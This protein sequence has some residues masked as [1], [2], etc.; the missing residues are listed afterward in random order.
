MN[1]L[2]AMTVGAILLVLLLLFSS[3]YTVSFHE[4]AIKSTFGEANEEDVITEPGLQFKLPFF[5]DNVDKFDTRLNYLQLADEEFGTSDQQTVV[6]R[7]F[8][9][10][11]VDP[12]NA[13]AFQRNYASIEEARSLLYDGFRDAM[14]EIGKFRFDDLLGVDSRIGEAEAA[15]MAKLG[16]LQ[17]RGIKVETVGISHLKLPPKATQAVLNRMKA[18]RTKLAEA[19][20]SRGKSEAERI[21]SNAR[22]MSSAIQAFADQLAE[23]I[24]AESNEQAA[25]YMT[26]MAEDEEF[27]RFLVQLDA[28]RA[29]LSQNTTVFVD[30]TS[31]PW[32]LMNLNTP[33][34]QNKIPVPSGAYSAKPKLDEAVADADTASDDDATMEGGE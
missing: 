28:L 22:T 21:K 27:A 4:V 29:T 12:D 19:E 23:E 25:R 33:L 10:W 30:D 1:K 7:G 9:F 3:T 31:S 2:V 8:L 11:R 24:R 26:T 5:A 34:G 20:R 16:N 15:V 32:H 14:S 13:L 18:T 17:E 6:V